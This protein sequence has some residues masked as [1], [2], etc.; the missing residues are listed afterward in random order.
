MLLA[1]TRAGYELPIIDVTHPRFAVADD[2]IA[3]A[4][5]QKEFLDDDK[6]RRWIPDFLLALLLR[7][8]ARNPGSPQPCSIAT[9]LISTALPPM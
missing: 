3:R 8:L 5:R 9:A 2:A 7:L 4:A 1:R 6:R